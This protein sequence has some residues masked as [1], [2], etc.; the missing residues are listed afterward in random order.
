L[1]APAEI[2]QPRQAP[3]RS[4]VA[5]RGNAPCPVIPA[6]AGIHAATVLVAAGW[7]PVF[8]GAVWWR[9]L[10]DLNLPPVIGHRGAA[11]YAPE[12]TFAGFRAARALGCAWVEFDVR[13]TLD[14]GLV[15]FH[16]DRLERT[17]DS[18]GRVARLPLATIRQADAGG[19]FGTKFA[20]ER[21]P[22]LDEA[23]LCC[24]ELRLGANIEIKAERSRGAATVEA[25]ADCLAQFAGGLGPILISSFLLDAVAEAAALMPSVPRGMLWRKLPRDWTD[26]AVR[27]GC[28]TIHCGQVNLTAKAVAAVG[29]AGYPLLAYTVNDAARARQLF[30]WG[31]TSV[32]SDAPDIVFAALAEEPAG[33]R[34]G[35]L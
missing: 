28:A 6:Q 35:A 33:A 2:S 17:S 29:A 18:E 13:L 20:G 24:R 26:V 30:D 23:L 14:R 11:A 19:W 10:P 9:V 7:I 3:P 22:T 15:V 27:L 1:A 31:V 34:R 5:G 32:F 12:N 16:D 21:I 4:D 8:A 25:V